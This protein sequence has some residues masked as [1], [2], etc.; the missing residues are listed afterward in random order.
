[1]QRIAELPPEDIFNHFLRHPGL[2]KELLLESS[3][4]RFTPSTFITEE[5]EGYNVGW[6]SRRFG[7]QCEVCFSDLADA[8][9]D[10]VLLSLGRGRW[11]R[12]AS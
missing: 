9:T 6:Y 4:K 3:D 2:A 11:K 1:M 10:Y 8:A 12:S 5:S 7:N